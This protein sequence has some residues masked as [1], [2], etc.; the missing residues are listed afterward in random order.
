MNEKFNLCY[1]STLI[2]YN[3][4]S[5][6]NGVNILFGNC[7]IS[8]CLP[9][10]LCIKMYKNKNNVHLL[11]IIIIITTI[12]TYYLHEFLNNLSKLY[13]IIYNMVMYKLDN[14]L[15]YFIFL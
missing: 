3:I 2:H 15:M 14:C 10:I 5:V 7:L 8:M 13:L 4:I 9:S 6:F 11:G 1:Q 12:V